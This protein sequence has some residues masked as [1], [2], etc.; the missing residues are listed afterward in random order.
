MSL[1]LIKFLESLERG[2]H[3]IIKFWI[4]IAGTRILTVRDIDGKYLGTFE[5]AQDIIDLKVDRA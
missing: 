4:N 2:E 5:A 1:I 3:H